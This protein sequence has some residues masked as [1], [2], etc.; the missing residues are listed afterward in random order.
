[1]DRSDISRR[2]LLSFSALLSAGL[3][4]SSCSSAENSDNNS[5]STP[6][7]RVLRYAN[8]AP[9]PSLDVASSGTLETARI[10]AQILEPL[11]QANSDTGEAEPALAQDWSLSSDQKTYTFQ[12]R[13]GVSFHDGSTLDAQAVVSNA[14]RWKK[15]AADATSN[16]HISYLQLFSKINSSDGKTPL[17]TDCSAQGQTVTF[18][19]SRPSASFLKALTQPAFG[20]AAPAALN[21]QGRFNK[22]PVGTGAYLLE[23]WDGKE[24][25]LS[26]YANY[27][28]QSP[29]V[30]KIHFLTISS[31]S[32][33]Y[34]A[35]Q[36]K[37]L[38][39]YD[40]VGM[41]HYVDLAKAGN[42]IQPRDPYAIS[43]LSI[44]LNN[45]LFKDIRIRQ[46]LAHAL[47][48]DA[49][50]KN[51]YPQGTRIA[52][53][54]LPSLF[55]MQDESTSAFY[56]YQLSKAQELLK[57]AGYNREKIE[58]YYPTD[59]S[60][61][62]LPEPEAMYAALSAD[63]IKAGFNVVPKPIPWGQ[64]YLDDISA[65]SSS[66]GLALTGFVG[67]Y[68]DP[69]AFYSRVLAT[70]SEVIDASS[71]STAPAQE[72]LS[73]E[74]IRQQAQTPSPSA[75][76]QE[77][78]PTVTY[79]QIMQQIRTADELTSHEERKEA[80]KNI[81]KLVAQLMPAVPIAYP[82]SAVAL[83]SKVSYYPLSATAISDFSKIS[84]T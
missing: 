49:A 46:A 21:A 70:T 73:E 78:E 40:L 61:A 71:D 57:A 17:V 18:Q 14:D 83:G 67:S 29:Q 7:E 42:L 30:D 41:A 16:A 63:L 23:S 12:L 62:F 32:K 52:N 50:V 64:G 31:A 45:K 11:V 3:A 8:A 27:W 39:I 34:Y 56:A 15:A 77:Q 84:M 76:S 28:G 54:F 22:L 82:V 69:N 13:E 25:I 36:T 19:L 43:Y 6:Q 26:R 51:L 38:D 68:R 60:L 35:M 65:S 59:V 81:N 75:S 5:S 44:N 79:Q 33:R 48:R 10:S 47:N 55:M 4:L 66:R 72:A 9:A 20:I 53:D 1:M 24:A 58:F 80:Y 37:Q 74:E 2:Q